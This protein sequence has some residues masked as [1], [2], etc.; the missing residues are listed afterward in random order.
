MANH[1]DKRIGECLMRIGVQGKELCDY[2]FDKNK[3]GGRI[4]LGIIKQ[5]SNVIV[6]NV[7]LLEELDKKSG[8]DA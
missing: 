2:I 8:G 6:S 3:N 7:E 5:M 4:G 1:N